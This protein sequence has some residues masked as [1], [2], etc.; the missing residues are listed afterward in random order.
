MAGGD[1]SPSP[2]ASPSPAKHRRRRS[3]DDDEANPDASP[4]RRR[5]KHHHRRRS[6]RHR[7]AD[8][9][10]LPPAAADGAGEDVEEGEILDDAAAADAREDLA[11]PQAAAPV[12]PLPSPPYVF[13]ILGIAMR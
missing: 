4:K 11:A 7:H 8:D 3:R 13:S 6:H 1:P 5:H 12:C 2:P 10:S 9:D